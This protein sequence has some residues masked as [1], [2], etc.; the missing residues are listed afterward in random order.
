MSI[1]L[2]AAGHGLPSDATRARMLDHARTEAQAG[3]LAATDAALPDLA[4][5]H[6]SAAGL[7]MARPGQV[8]IGNTTSQFWLAAVA[9]LPLAGRRLLVAPHEWGNHIRY[10]RHVAPGL[11]LRLEVM[12]PADA[13]DPAAWAARIDGDVA[14][15]LLPH[16]TS[17]QGLVYPLAQ[18]AALPRPDTSLVVVDAAQSVGRLDLPPGWDVV[19]ATARKW[20]RGPRATAML[21]LSAR[22]E[23][24]LGIQV[25][26]LEPMDANIG[27]RL[28]MNVALAEA[29]AAGV[30]AIAARLT[31]MAQQ[32]R[33]LLA[34]GDR[35]G[36]WLQAG[37]PAAA[38]APGHIT[39]AVPLE[40]KAA[41]SDRL[42]QAGITAKW[43]DP[44]HEEPLSQPSA[45][46]ALL[47]ITPHLY[48]TAAE[49]EALAAALRF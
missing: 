34:R 3:T 6:Q 27:L 45:T 36:Q 19:A 38:T 11:N 8:A 16:V 28:G 37:T 17:A 24:V 7:L 26:G 33:Q 30:P 25:R 5:L 10:L 18:I 39:L 2:N 23:T 43:A 14:A 42:L 22:A 21:A 4:E 13:L 29:R 9:R 35:T 20:L 15:L 40:D 46:T 32:I 48:S 41:V 31:A 1:Y 44:A 12:P 49:A 47:R